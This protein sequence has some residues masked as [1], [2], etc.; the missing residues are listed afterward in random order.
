MD[1]NLYGGLGYSKEKLQILFS[2][3]QEIEIR[4]M[5][6]INLNHNE[7]GLEDFIVCM[8]KKV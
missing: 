2:N 8:F 6:H 5:H 3:F 7:F 1:R 4:D